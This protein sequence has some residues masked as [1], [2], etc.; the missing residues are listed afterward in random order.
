MKY[1]VL[2][3]IQT[4]A[5]LTSWKV[6]EKFL[7]PLFEDGRLIPERAATFGEVS[8]SHGFD[9]QDIDD[10]RTHWASKAVMCINGFSE[11]FT[12]DFHWIRRKIAKS[13]GYVFFC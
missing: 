7:S 1:D 3:K 8:A 10:C 2:I 11:K 13:Q 4:Y 6:G 9:V 5:D 12:E